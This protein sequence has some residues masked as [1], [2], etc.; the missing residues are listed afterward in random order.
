ME[1]LAGADHL[2]FDPTRFSVL[3]RRL[4][5]IVHKMQAALIRTSRSGV[6]SS[7]HDCSCCLL[8]ADS[9]LVT[10]ADS[11]PIHVMVGPDDMSRAMHEYHPVLRRGD[12][13]LH[14]SPYHGNS[15]AADLSILVPVI[16]DDG[17]HRFTVL[18][19]AHQADI[20]N[21][22][23]T[24]YMPTARDIYEEGAL[25]FPAVK[26]Q[27]DYET[28]EDIVR[29]C[30]MRIRV[31][32]QWH[33]DFIALLGA[34]RVG[35]R[36]ILAL[37]REIGWDAL[38]DYIGAWLDYGDSM[39]S[40][41]IAGLPAGRATAQTRHDHFPGTPEAG[42]PVRATVEIDP[43]ERRISVDIT[44][45]IDC[46][47]CGLNLSE[48][49]ARSAAL[50]GLFNS[51]GQN[52]PANAGSI[53][54]IEVKLR[55]NCVVGIPRHP[56]SVSVA[57][58]NIADRLASAVHCA[59]AK[60]ADGIG[61][62]EAGSTEGPGGAVISGHDPRSGNKPFVNQL[63]LG[64]TGGPAGPREDG[65]LTLGNVCTAGFWL[66]DSVE[67]DELNFP[68]LVHERRLVPDTE[69]AG[70]HRGAPGCRMLLGTN[71]ADVRMMYASDGT[72]NAAQGVRGGAAGANASQW[73]ERS[74]GR[75]EE[76]PGVGD[77]V[78]SPGDV[79]VCDTCGG[80]GYG[81]PLERDPARVRR[82][83]AAGLVSRERA[84]LIYGVALD[85]DGAID[86]AATSGLRQK[87]GQP[88]QS[89]DMTNGAAP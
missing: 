81:S 9:E 68:L 58:T 29:M 33:G 75:V 10:V 7:G 2:S 69:G 59:M 51:L 61:L 73:I 28:I 47:P 15:H 71:G 70:R 19:K 86:E 80:G 78:L 84:R 13:F 74:D 22:S 52:I 17:I 89:L 60:I 45:N 18:S 8:S 26:V 41:A 57:T 76:L 31:P 38:E 40:E 54:R 14:N 44:D 48:A 72:Q 42:V 1:P 24:T 62:A 21:A 3:A 35:E 49:C 77:F 63:A 16:D 50:V 85:H 67:I 4:D 53:R 27:E 83:V 20:G 43:V 66:M 32:D 34:A 37:G 87:S 11:I 6:I 82:D 5:G 36:E 30:R 79:V 25:L 39:M 88:A 55:E 64:D 12:A 23:P 46:M 56:T 65:W